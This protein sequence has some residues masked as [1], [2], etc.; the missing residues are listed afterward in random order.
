[1]AISGAAELLGY[2]PAFAIVQWRAEQSW[3]AGYSLR[4]GVRIE[5]ARLLSSRRLYL[6]G[7][8]F[9]GGS[10]NGQFSGIHTRSLG[11]GLHLE[12]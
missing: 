11:L 5:G 6:L 12:F 8:Y 10:P 4:A 3:R 9:R 2:R 1:M 7:E